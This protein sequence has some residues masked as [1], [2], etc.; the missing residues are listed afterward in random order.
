MPYQT[1]APAR[2][3]ISPKT[4]VTLG[5]ALVVFAGIAGPIAAFY[6]LKAELRI[7]AKDV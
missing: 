7:F 4:Q 6:S 2:P 3:L 1:Q 5:L